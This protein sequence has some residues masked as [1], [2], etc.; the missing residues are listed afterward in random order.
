MGS[1]AINTHRH[2]GKGFSIKL[3]YNHYT[4]FEVHVQAEKGNQLL[5]IHRDLALQLI[6]YCIGFFPVGYKI[7]FFRSLT[8]QNDHMNIVYKSRHDAK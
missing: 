6:G 7:H 3:S 2:K 8:S 4:L 1:T 5:L